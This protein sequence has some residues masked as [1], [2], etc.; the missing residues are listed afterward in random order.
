M[1]KFLCIFDNIGKVFEVYDYKETKN[2]YMFKYDEIVCWERRTRSRRIKKEEFHKWGYFLDAEMEMDALEKRRLADVLFLKEELKHFSK[3]I[4]EYCNENHDSILGF[5]YDRDESD[6]ITIINS[7]FEC[8]RFV[9]KSVFVG[10]LI[11]NMPKYAGLKDEWK[12]WRLEFLN[13]LMKEFNIN[14]NWGG[15]SRNSKLPNISYLNLEHPDIVS[16]LTFENRIRIR[17]KRNNVTHSRVVSLNSAY[18]D[19]EIAVS[20]IPE[21]LFNRMCEN[22]K[23]RYKESIDFLIVTTDERLIAHFLT[24][25]QEYSTNVSDKGIFEISDLKYSYL[26]NL[27]E[28][29]TKNVIKL[30]LFDTVVYTTIDN[31][32]ERLRKEKNRFYFKDFTGYSRYGMIPDN[33]YTRKVIKKAIGRDNWN[34]LSLLMEADND[35]N[36]QSFE[37]LLKKV[38]E[39]LLNAYRNSLRN[40]TSRKLEIY[41]IAVFK[42][43]K[44]RANSYKNFEFTIYLRKP[45][46]NLASFYY[47]GTA[48]HNEHY[49]NPIVKLLDY[50]R[51]DNDYNEIKINKNT[52]VFIHEKV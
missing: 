48:E 8:K 16:T 11:S 41:D 38:K 1:K 27:M 35:W 23:E 5:G 4:N 26:K 12:K 33:E 47:S 15:G 17:S 9:L 30:D 31:I 28:M 37:R 2:S 52:S 44:E 51:K 36:I 6:Y 49:E 13:N 24:D 45:E 18:Y 14:T 46:K 20:D 40:T 22:R 3:V 29:L 25:E 19:N 50:I 39:N 7:N 42:V 32:L 21:A 34:T 43:I 10:F